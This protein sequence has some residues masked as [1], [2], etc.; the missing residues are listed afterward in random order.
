MPPDTDDLLGRGRERLAQAGG[1][2]GLIIPVVLALAS[3]C[4][5]TSF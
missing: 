5:W 4:A 2:R 1:P 3:L